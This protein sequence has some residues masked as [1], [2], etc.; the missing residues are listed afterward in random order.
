MNIRQHQDHTM[1][2]DRLNNVW[3][4]MPPI[5]YAHHMRKKKVYVQGIRGEKSLHP[6]G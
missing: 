6:L 4:P 3:R 2:G 1:A 5:T